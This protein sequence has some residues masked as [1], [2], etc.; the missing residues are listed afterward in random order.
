[1]HPGP[2]KG[3]RSNMMRPCQPTGLA[4]LHPAIDAGFESAL[5]HQEQ[6]EKIEQDGCLVIGKAAS[7]LDRVPGLQLN[8]LTSHDKCF[9]GFQ[10]PRRVV[11]RRQTLRALH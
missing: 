3:P 10:R 7:V 2:G 4:P 1:M 5:K 9:C 11:S 6:K 8:E